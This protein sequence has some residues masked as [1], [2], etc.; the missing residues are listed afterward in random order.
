MDF[1]KA[2]DHLNWKFLDS[3]MAQMKFPDKWRSWIYGIV[4]S[5][6]SSVLVNGSP[7][8]EFKC[9][10]GI[11]QG[12]PISPFLFILAMEAFSFLLNKDLAEGLFIGFSTPNNG[13]NISHLLYAD[14]EMI[15]G[16]WSRENAK[17]LVRLLRCFNLLSGLKIN[18]QKSSFYGVGVSDA[19][20]K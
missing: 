14:D 3:V 17:N 11:R 1:E 6:K 7:T 12:D 9:S 4:S 20:V 19:A 5:A 15:I 13:P 2:Y 10:R 18:L 16:E 8:F